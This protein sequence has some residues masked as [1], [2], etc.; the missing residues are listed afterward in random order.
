[1]LKM[2]LRLLTPLNAILGIATLFRII[3]GKINLLA[4]D[5]HLLLSNMI[6][7]YL[8]GNG[9]SPSIELCN[10]CFHPKLYHFLTGAIFYLF[11][12]TERIPQIII[13]QYL[14][15]VVGILTLVVFKVFFEE[16]T[17]LPSK[18][19]SLGFAFIAFNPSLLKLHVQATNDSL[20]V[21][22]GVLATYFLY[23]FL[24]SQQL[25]HSWIVTL[26]VILA[27]LTKGNA[28]VL[29]VWILV[30]IIFRIMASHYY[31]KSTRIWYKGLA[32]FSVSLL[33]LFKAANSD[34]F[35]YKYY[36]DN[37][38][39]TTQL[40]FNT[41]FKASDKPLYFF[42][43]TIFP[44]AGVISV[45]DSFFTFRLFDL[46]NNPIMLYNNEREVKPLHRTSLWSQM[47]GRFHF[48][49]FES[50]VWFS[51]NPFDFILGAVIFIFAL[52]PTF[53]I[54][55]GFLFHLFSL[56]PR[57]GKSITKLLVNTSEW[58][59]PIQLILFLALLINFCLAWRGYEAMKDTYVFP[60]LLSF[61]Y[62]YVFFVERLLKFKG[63]R[64][65][66]IL[67]ANLSVL[68]SLYLIHIIFVIRDIKP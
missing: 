13:A 54:L 38:R 46:I 51:E 29:V 32:V 60:A 15:V 36:Y 5:D 40:T 12:I 18:F 64:V 23:K 39:D 41:H 11:D 59:F 53:F 2:I 30:V 52:V 62:A 48:G 65:L 43:Q 6:T 25:R 10:V 4:N 49:Y 68:I 14:N 28:L 37:W 24:K 20:V 1:M 34:I 16:Q 47:Y 21:F 66:K 17:F 9:P 42:E 26:S 8:Q 61:L 31:N 57:K 45:Y 35:P 27:L 63:Q 58:I 55:I 19:K 50:W 56:I 7:N 22:F 67:S 3:L 44:G 33:I